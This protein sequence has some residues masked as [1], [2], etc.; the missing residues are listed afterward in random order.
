MVK[1]HKPFSAVFYDF[2]SVSSMHMYICIFITY[3]AVP[4]ITGGIQMYKNAA[5][6][7]KFDFHNENRISLNAFSRSPLY[8]HSLCNVKVER[9]VPVSRIFLNLSLRLFKVFCCA[10][11]FYITIQVLLYSRSLCS[12]FHGGCCFNF[13]FCV[14]PIEPNYST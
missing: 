3:A 5:S 1:L 2:S 7:M 11:Y 8:I 6:K 12:L 13:F 10:F 4:C 14:A 9:C